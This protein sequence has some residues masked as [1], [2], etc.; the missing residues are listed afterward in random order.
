MTASIPNRRETG[1]NS[2]ISGFKKLAGGLN[3]K[4]H[5][6]PEIKKTTVSGTG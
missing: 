4:S 2:E 3:S 5:G 1:K 6:N